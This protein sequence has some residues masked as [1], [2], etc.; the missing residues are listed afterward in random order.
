LY[1]ASG[2]AKILQ[3]KISTTPNLNGI[4]RHRSRNEV[5]TF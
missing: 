5:W 1:K 2:G 3:F 4:L